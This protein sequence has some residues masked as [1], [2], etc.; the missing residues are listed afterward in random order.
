MFIPIRTDYRMRGK[1][2]VNYALVAANVL[3]YLLGYNGGNP[4]IDSLLLHPLDPQFHQF[5]TCVF[6]HANFQHLLGNMVFLWVFGN[7]INDRF[8]HLGYLAFYLAGGIMACVG[9]MLLG[10]SAPVLGASG[11]IAAVTG[12]YLV[13]LPRA[14]V[15]ILLWFWII[16]TFEVSSLYFL[17]F[18]FIQDL[19]MTVT[20]VGGLAS[21]GGGVAYAAHVTGSVFGVCVAAAM[22]AVKLLP[23]DTFD[24]LNVIQ[25]GHRR[26]R[27]RAMADRGFDPFGGGAAGRAAARPVSVKTAEPQVPDSRQAR[28]IRLRREIADA[29]RAHQMPEA[30][31]RYLQ[32]LQIAD[33]VVLSQQ[34]QLDVSNFLMSDRQYPASADAYERFVRHYGGYAD[35]GDI[36]LMLGLLYGRYLQQYDRAEQMLSAAAERLA[37]TGKL[38][39]ARTELAKARQKRRG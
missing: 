30:A 23:R 10:G 29:C 28:E 1:P 20:T 36:Y 39:M 16:T 8:G 18:Y 6:L 4:R 7:A 35:M 21:A 15:T 34:N 38:E 11:A 26:R 14:R 27:Y 25:H 2:W 22:L 24:L 17:L 13:L 32:L 5:L 3:L 33:D 12:V 9:Y 31:R 19:V 37:D